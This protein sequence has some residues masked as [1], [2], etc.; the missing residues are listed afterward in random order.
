MMMMITMM[1]TIITMTTM[2]MMMREIAK[3]QVMG[4]SI[5]TEVVDQL[6]RFNDALTGLEDSCQDECFCSA[7]Q[8]FQVFNFLVFR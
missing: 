6:R 4:E 1:I 2:L 7:E 3:L 5:P 8:H